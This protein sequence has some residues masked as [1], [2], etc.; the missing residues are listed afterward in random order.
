MIARGVEN[1]NRRDIELTTHD[2]VFKLGAA[3][4]DTD[5]LVLRVDDCL[6]LAQFI[7]GLLSHAAALN[8]NGLLSEALFGGDP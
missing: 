6:R 5:E 4:A 8:G 2:L 3:G 1:I 7:G